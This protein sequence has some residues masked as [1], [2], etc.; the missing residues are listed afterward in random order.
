MHQRVVLTV[1]REVGQGQRKPAVARLLCFDQASTRSADQLD[2]CVQIAFP[3][4]TLNAANMLW[5][6]ASKPT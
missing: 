1:L 5:Q 6:Q 4:A 2:F 3:H